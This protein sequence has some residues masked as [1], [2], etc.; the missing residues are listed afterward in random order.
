MTVRTLTSD[1][2]SD[3]AGL[4]RCDLKPPALR[5]YQHEAIAAARTSLLSHRSTLIVAATGTGKTVTFAELTRLEVSH[6]GKVLIIV[7]RDELIRQAAKKCEAIGLWP[8]VE[9]GKQRANTLGKLVIA[10]VQ[11]LRGARLL[12]W[13]RTHFTL[14]IVDEAHHATAT[15][16]RGVLDHFDHA[17][18]VGV[19]ATPDRTDGVGLGDVFQCVAY[20]YE[21]RQAIDEGYLVP[22][23][24]R[25]IVVDSVDLSS[26]ATRGGDFAQDQLS[27]VM[28]QETALRGVVVPLLE[29]ATDRQTIGFCVD[30]AHAHAVTD[31]LNRY[32]PG[33]ARAVSGKTEDGE[34]E[35]MLAAHAGGEFQFLLNCD[36]LVEGY[37]SPTVACVAM[38]RPTKSRSRF[39]Q[40]GGRGLRPSPGK[41]DCLILDFTGTASKHRL[42]GPVDC[43]VGR[44]LDDDIRDEIDR[45]LSSAQ[46]PLDAVLD[47]ATSEVERRRASMKITAIV[48]YHAE[49]IDPFIGE[50]DRSKMPPWSTAWEQEPASQRQLEALDRMG[51]TISKLPPSF[52]RADAW[53][54]LCRINPRVDAGLCSYKMARKLASA[55]VL[56]TLTLTHGRARELMAMLSA[57]GWK[58]KTIENEPEVRGVAE[59]IRSVG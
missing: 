17:K 22:I 36:V 35:S 4:S 40:C 38:I 33:C 39:V 53:R 6:G 57:G 48:R 16:Y 2:A 47:H 52:S 1:G 27:A 14:I 41:V 56:D 58:P 12:R 31:M 46:L 19:T 7:H 24:A 55:G 50:E 44:E 37:D 20:R 30:V 34:R 11:S 15:G 49:H 29:L 25:R 42:V 23:T 43:L 10:S 3:L 8:D 59:S 32:R 18:I 21:I 28:A 13:A 26:V 54:L 45:K 9:K 5:R 51:L